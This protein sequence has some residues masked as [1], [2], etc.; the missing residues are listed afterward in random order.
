MSKYVK[1]IFTST[2]I[3]VFA[4]VSIFGSLIAISPKASAQ[5][6]TPDRVI[7]RDVRN[8]WGRVIRTEKMRL[9]GNAGYDY[10][11]WYICSY[12]NP[13]NTSRPY[14]KIWY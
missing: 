12:M 8:W 1:N 2:T 9:R 10:R 3:I 11:S 14:Y 13:K 6:L 7:C 4:I 5:N